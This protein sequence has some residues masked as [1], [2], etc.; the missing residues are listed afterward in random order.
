[1][2]K[3]KCELCGSIDIVKTANNLFE[4]QH[5]GCKYTLEQARFLI[6]GT[7]TA[8]QPDFT[9]RAGKLEEYNGESVD[10]VIP[11]NV[12]HIGHAAFHNCSGLKSVVIPNSV[13]DIGSSAFS[14]CSGLTRITIPSSVTSI[15]YC[16][17][18]DCS[19]LTSI[20]L[21]SS[22]TSIGYRAFSGC[23][24]L[25]S[26]TIQCDLKAFAS[27]IDS[28]YNRHF[29]NCPKLIN[30]QPGLTEDQAEK[31]GLT[32]YLS[33]IW[34]FENRCTYCGGEFKLLFNKCK[35]C[36]RPKNY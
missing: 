4:C 29:E 15:G 2:R 23:S 11:D 22:V 27:S 16:A 6:E 8:I 18:S 12:T 36:D 10:V 19:R 1:M 17:F 21:P 33:K 20:T 25:T 31:L 32:A 5:C 24:S 26:V 9:I 14:G 35:K 34:Q 30:V 7:V 28:Y 13:I 3:L